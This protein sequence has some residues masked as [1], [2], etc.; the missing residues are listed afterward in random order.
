[1]NKQDI[2][3]YIDKIVEEDRKKDDKRVKAHGEYERRN[4]GEGKSVFDAYFDG[5][6][7]N[8]ETPQI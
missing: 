1:M 8:E 5:V 6:D 7:D 2:K 3:D 4:V